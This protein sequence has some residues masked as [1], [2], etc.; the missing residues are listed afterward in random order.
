LAEELG[1][2]AQID[3]VGNVRWDRVLQ[4]FQLCT[5]FVVSS[6]HDDNGN[7]DAMPT[8]LLEAMA[9]GRP[10]VA[11]NVN[12]IPL[13]VEDGVTGLVV[14]ERNVPQ[15]VDAIS[16]LLDDPARC[17]QYGQAARQRV[18]AQLNWHEVARKLEGLYQPDSAQRQ[19]SIV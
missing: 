19:R 15:L 3:F 16:S 18:E 6:I 8:T 14:E 4:Y 9:A 17:Q 13:V 12:G 5:L 7:A 10:I 11:T 2:A 1:V